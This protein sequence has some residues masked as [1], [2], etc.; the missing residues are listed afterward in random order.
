ML[1]GPVIYPN[2]KFRTD[3]T[4]QSNGSSVEFDGSLS[5]LAAILNIGG[6]FHFVSE[7]VHHTFY[8]WRL[9]RAIRALYSGKDVPK[10]E[11]S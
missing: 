3:P 7:S 5:E 6:Q 11:E 9:S 4:R 1:A 8:D 10:V 2:I